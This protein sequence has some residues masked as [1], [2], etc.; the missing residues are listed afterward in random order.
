ME[1]TKQFKF[2]CI[3]PRQYVE[4]HSQYTLVIFQTGN[5]RIMGCKKEIDLL[6]LPYKITNV[7]LQS[8]TVTIDLEQQIHLRNLHMNLGVL[9][10][11]EPELF[12]ALRYTKYNP[13][14]V[15]VFS[16]GKVVILGLKT[17][18]FHS[19]TDQIKQDL[20]YNQ[21]IILILLFI[22][23]ECV[24]IL[25]KLNYLIQKKISMTL[26]RII[27]YCKIL[28][29]FSRFRGS[30]RCALDKLFLRSYVNVVIFNTCINMLT[31]YYL[32]KYGTW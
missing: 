32:F 20:R 31:C 30:I 4:K 29:I 1:S 17:L 7:I 14:C 2:N 12:C 25:E 26:V 5:C 22:L 19:I 23:I 11:F 15:N 28:M 9:S 6:N 3:K 18:D 10:M 21:I 27:S 24:L 8:V 16:S 13:L